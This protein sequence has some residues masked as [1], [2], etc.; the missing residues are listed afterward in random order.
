MV[1][2]TA[3]GIYG[4]DVSCSIR[5]ESNESKEEFCSITWHGIS[6]CTHS[7]EVYIVPF[8]TREATAIWEGNANSA[9]MFS[10]QI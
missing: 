3:M 7:S 10:N 1:S 9:M 2:N 6:Y 4:T 5:M 8:E